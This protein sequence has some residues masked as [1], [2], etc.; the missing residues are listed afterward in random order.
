[1]LYEV[2][3]LIRLSIIDLEAGLLQPGDNADF[4]IVDNLERMNV[5]ETWIRGEK[6]FA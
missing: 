1:M 2:P 3:Q 5:I 4:I 6:V